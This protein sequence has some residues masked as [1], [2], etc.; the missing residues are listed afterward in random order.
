MPKGRVV[1]QGEGLLYGYTDE[2][3]ASFHK[4]KR[5]YIRNPE[6]QKLAYKKWASTKSP[7][8][9]SLRARKSQLKLQY[10]MTLEDY[11]DLLKAQ[12]FKCAICFTDKPTGKWK[13]F[14]VDHC[15]KTG[16]V[17]GLLCNEC[18]S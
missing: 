9:H 18:I 16:K 8:S 12:N 17:R 11:D 10:G 6:K 1:R 4:S 7:E 2:E 13:V 14:T 5:A 3:W 15:H